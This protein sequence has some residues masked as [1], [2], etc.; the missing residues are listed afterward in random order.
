LFKESPKGNPE[1]SGKAPDP[2]SSVA[3]FNIFNIGNSKP[4]KLMDFIR[5]IENATG[6]KA[7]IEYRPMQ[8]GDVRK[9]YANVEQ[10]I[11]RIGFSPKTSIDTGIHNFIEW[12]L[13][14]FELKPS[15][16]KKGVL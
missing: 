16:V 1:W 7:I 11:S 4:V 5:A 8:P 13:N 14:Y 3:A 12:Y 2:S 15:G 9:T 10:L 6:K